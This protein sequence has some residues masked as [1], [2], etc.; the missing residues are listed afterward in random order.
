MRSVILYVVYVFEL[1]LSHFICM[2]FMD[3][4]WISRYISLIYC[5]NKIFYENSDH[6]TSLSKL[7][8]A[9]VSLTLLGSQP[10][11]QNPDSLGNDGLAS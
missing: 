10:N 4:I 9:F 3:L 1:P 6:V 2:S 5:I 8:S 7:F 11:H